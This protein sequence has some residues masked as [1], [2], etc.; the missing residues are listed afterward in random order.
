MAFA[1][2]QSVT[3]N[4]VANSLPRTSSG[5]SSGKFT[6]DDGN[7][8]LTV[9]HQY[10]K[11]T[12][13]QLRLDFSKIA[14]DPLISAQNI[15]YSMSAYLVVDIPVTGFTVVEQKQIVDALTAYLTASSGARVTQLLGGEN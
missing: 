2:P 9:S 15:K 12:R 6:K 7:V 1:D 4:A 11:R 5:T 8:A 3:I 10:G 14:P 13:R